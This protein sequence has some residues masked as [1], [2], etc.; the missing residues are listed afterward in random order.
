MIE[1]GGGTSSLLTLGLVVLT[2]ILTTIRERRKAQNDAIRIWREEV[3]E[4][5]RHIVDESTKHYTTLEAKKNTSSSAAIILNELKRLGHKLRR[6]S[7]RSNRNDGESCFRYLKFT[8]TSS[9][10]FQ[11]AKRRLRTADDPILANIRDAEEQLLHACER[12]VVLMP[13]K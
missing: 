8:I 6:A 10:D 9:D 3:T 2:H 12:D 5:V 13:R 11:D 4:I 7:F 1:G